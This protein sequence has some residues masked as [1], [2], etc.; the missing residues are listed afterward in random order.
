MTAMKKASS[1]ANLTYTE[2][3]SQRILDW[4]RNWPQEWKEYRRRWEENPKKHDPGEF[5][6]H[7]DIEATRA[8]NLK[9]VMCFRT[10][11]IASGEK[12]PEGDMDFGLYKK[13]VDEG[14]QNGLCSIKLSYLG[15]PLISK[16]I[17]RM[18][19]YA[20]D[21]GILDVMFNTNGVL[22]TQEMSRKLIKAGITGVFISFDSPYKDHFE[23]IRVG[24]KFESVIKNVEDLVRI[25]KEM[26]SFFPII[27][28]SMTVM[29]ENENEIPQYMKL[30]QPIV[31]AIGF[32]HYVDPHHQDKKANERRAFQT[33]KK[34]FFVCPQIYQRLVIHWDGRIGLCCAD[35]D[36]EMHL[37]NAKNVTIKS[38]WLGKEL[39]H[40]RRLS[41]QGSWDKI[42]LCLKCDLPYS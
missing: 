36:A 5:P 26:D 11:K 25:R 3:K 27:R 31:D 9:C 40:Y 34:D 19:E 33:K 32:G 12:F 29:K 17:V 23:S 21:K 24:A 42:P 1:S 10:V 8:C 38:V 18:T 14:A 28:V 2:Y 35:Y 30:W 16:D 41:E 13:I 7:L 22:L 37:G 20:K 4:E 15:E 6:I 39:Q